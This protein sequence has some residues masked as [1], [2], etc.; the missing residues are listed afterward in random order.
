MDLQSNPMSGTLRIAETP[1]YG[2]WIVLPILSRF[3]ALQPDITVKPEMSTTL[4][5]LSRQTLMANYGTARVTDQA[6]HP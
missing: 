3:H 2:N 5:I 6:L 4:S 1:F